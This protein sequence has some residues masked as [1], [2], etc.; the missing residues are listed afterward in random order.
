M[1][2]GECQRLGIALALASRP[3]LLL[4]DEVT[5]SLDPA[6]GR[7]IADILEAQLGS[8][9]MAMILVSHQPQIVARLARE[10]LEL[11][12]GQVMRAGTEEIQFSGQSEIAT[13]HNFVGSETSLCAY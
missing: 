8:G 6:N 9:D 5:A 13:E 7:A 3:A 12:D 2:G 11:R 10:V 1:S 4:L